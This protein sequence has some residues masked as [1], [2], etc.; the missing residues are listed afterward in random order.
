[1]TASEDKEWAQRVLRAGW[2]LAL[3]PFLVVSVDHRLRSGVRDL[4]RRTSAETRELVLRTGMPPVTGREAV[5]TW[6]SDVAVDEHT[7]R[8]LQRLNYFRIA[9]IGGRY[10]G[11]RQAGRV[12]RSLADGRAFARFGPREG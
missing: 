5:R 10:L 12:W 3:D 8:I 6:W 7:P 2:R 4:V 1:M 9:E 11:S